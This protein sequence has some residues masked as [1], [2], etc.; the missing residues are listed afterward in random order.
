M[1]KKKIILI[2]VA[3]LVL[4]GLAAFL[5]LN[6]SGTEGVSTTQP[7]SEAQ[8]E[9]TELS[10]EAQSVS[11]EW[12]EEE[13]TTQESTTEEFTISREVYDAV[14]TGVWY[15]YD[16][17]A[18][19]AYAFDFT[20]KDRVE[21][22]YFDKNNAE[23]LD[24]KYFTTS[25]DYEIND[26]EGEIIIELEDPI[27]DNVSFMFTVRDGKIRYGRDVL[28]NEKEVSLDTVFNHFNE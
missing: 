20:G 2:I 11:V 15:L 16:E 7:S 21:I 18:K 14:K 17:K 1:D 13:S 12:T 23:G 6:K 19:T 4:I 25:E 24:A 27:N 9:V 3:L 22:A 28:P 8:S 10:T 5:W 26:V